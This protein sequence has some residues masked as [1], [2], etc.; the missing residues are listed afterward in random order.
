MKTPKS[1]CI[2]FFA[3]HEMDSKI[4]SSTTWG[5]KLFKITLRGKIHAI[6]RFFFSVVDL[7]RGGTPMPMLP[8]RNDDGERG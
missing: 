5:G 6:R 7:P 4:E 8:G 1:S 3:R 2:Q